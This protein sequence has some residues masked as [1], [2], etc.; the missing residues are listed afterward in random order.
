[1]KNAEENAF[2]VRPGE[3][4]TKGLTKREYFA[5]MAMQGELAAQNFGSGDSIYFNDEATRREFSR[6]CID[7]ADTL[8]AELEKQPN[9][10]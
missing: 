7:F 8:L 6:K 4:H 3:M 10:G 9:N 1:M 2:P 5:A